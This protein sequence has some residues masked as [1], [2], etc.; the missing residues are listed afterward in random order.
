[1]NPSVLH[2][3]RATMIPLAFVVAFALSTMAKAD[4]GDY[5][6]TVVFG[7]FDGSNV[8]R[9]VS[10]PE[11]DCGKGAIHI[12][13]SSGSVTTWTRDTSG[14]L[15]TAACGDYFG[16]SL[17]VGDFNG[18]SY[19]DLAVGIPGAAVSGHANA[20]AVHVI[21]GSSTGLTTTGDQLVAPE[22]AGDLRRRGAR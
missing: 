9:V 4:F 6:G 16:A 22:L 8:T 14:L 19:V 21:Y 7:R 15:G 2:L 17:A 10:S 13:E 20:G 1:M 12:V 11:H 3:L 18:D 5:S